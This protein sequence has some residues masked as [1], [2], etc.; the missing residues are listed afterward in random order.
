M[1][2]SHFPKLVPPNEEFPT[3]VQNLK[4]LASSLTTTTFLKT[5]SPRAENHPILSEFS[6]LELSKYSKQLSFSHFGRQGQGF[7]LFAK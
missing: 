2:Q 7:I 5:H 6:W 3:Y 4:L 1:F